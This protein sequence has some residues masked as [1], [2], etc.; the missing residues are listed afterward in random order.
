MMHDPDDMNPTHTPCSC[1]PGRLIGLGRV[2]GWVGVIWTITGCLFG[3]GI[4]VHVQV[5]S[6]L[7]GPPFFKEE[8]WVGRDM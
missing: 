1:L 6:P 3:C 8:D 5:Y 7:L 2:W 4:C